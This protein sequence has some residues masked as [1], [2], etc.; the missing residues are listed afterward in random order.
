MYTTTCIIIFSVMN[1]LSR[2]LKKFLH[3]VNMLNIVGEYLIFFLFVSYYVR[4]GVLHM[5]LDLNLIDNE[6]NAKLLCQ[7]M[8]CF[9]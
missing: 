8:V 3:V 6:F 5:T 7:V 4:S 2:T 1:H 9:F